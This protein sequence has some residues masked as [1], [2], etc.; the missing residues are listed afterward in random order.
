MARHEQGRANLTTPMRYKR[1]SAGGVAAARTRATRG[2]P[3]SE[4]LLP[5]NPSLQ[6]Q[7]GCLE[8]VSKSQTPWPEQ[9]WPLT[10]GH[11]A[12]TRQGGQA[13]AE[14]ETSTPGGSGG[15]CSERGE[16]GG[17]SGNARRRAGAS[18]CLPT[19]SLSTP[20]PPLFSLGQCQRRR[21]WAAAAVL[22]SR[23]AAGGVVLAEELEL[24]GAGLGVA[25]RAH[26]V[27]AAEVAALVAHLHAARGVSGLNKGPRLISGV[28]RHVG[29]KAVA[30]RVGGGAVLARQVEVLKSRR[31]GAQRRLAEPAAL[32]PEPRR[33]RREFRAA[34]QWLGAAARRKRRCQGRGRSRRA[35]EP[36]A[37]AVGSAARGAGS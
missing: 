7:R 1:V 12:A 22:T 37:I 11:S 31:R 9:R 6:K 14:G 25:A 36:S 2:S 27:C 24:Q 19:P 13:A 23:A 32:Q 17:G 26:A 33:K 16:R 21:G 4:Q 15:G 5:W 18:P 8:V 30:L 20:S 35:S 34:R 29:R 3:G 10:I 28:G